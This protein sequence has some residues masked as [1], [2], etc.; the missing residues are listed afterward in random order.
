M[1]SLAF[2]L[3]MIPG[4]EKV[5]SADDQLRAD[6]AAYL[7]Y[8]GSEELKHFLELEKEVTSNEFATRKKE[9]LK[10]NY[11]SSE[12]M[13]KEKMYKNQKRKVKGDDIPED[14][15]ALEKEIESEAFQKRKE[16]LQLSPKE[17]Y[18]STPE[19]NKEEEYK[20]LK[21]SEKVVWYFK[22]K[23]K[24]PF[25]EIEKWEESFNESFGDGKLN[26]KH[27]MTRY[28]WGNELLDEPYT[29]ADDKSF[30]TDGKNLEFSEKSIKLLARKEEVDG[31]KWDPVHGFLLDTFDYTSALISTGKGFRQKY[32]MF[33]AKI[34]MASSDLS[35]AFWMVSDGLLPH[36]DIAKFEKGKLYSNY[37][38]ASDEMKTPSRSVTKTGGSRFTNNFHIFSLEWSPE[39]MVWKI[40]DKV[41]KTQTGNIPQ[42]EMYMVFSAML[43]DWG[44]ERGLPSGMEIDWVRVYKRKEDQ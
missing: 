8:D 10:D 2:M 15:A 18:A 23:K 21:N 6:F 32:G 16:Y 22:T 20:E 40:N 35:Q 33:K 29:M 25:K 30:P 43:K 5:E 12:E 3:G 1:A 42:E 31:K 37:F 26:T 39:K 36:V 28:Y 9:I 41:F 19:Y 4:T 14:L 13:S 11:K 24:Y 17:R 7:A 27:W 44:S 34:K 38:W